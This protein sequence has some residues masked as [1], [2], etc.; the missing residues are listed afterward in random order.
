[1]FFR[2]SLINAFKENSPIF[3]IDKKGQAELMETLL[4]LLVIVLLIVSGIF[5]YYK[6]FLNSL[7]NLGTEKED[8]QNLILLYVFSSMPEVKCENDDCVDAV[9]LIAFKDLINENK[10]YYFSKFGYK[11]IIV[12]D[13]YPESKNSS[14][15]VECTIDKY[16]QSVFP[17]NCG[18]FVVYDNLNAKE[19]YGVSLPVSLYFANLNEYKIGRIIIKK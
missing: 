13:V 1:M 17:E 18:F 12:E 19:S 7:G 2:R 6:F 16:Q 15:T 8:T 14:K 10:A 9:K 4:I 5:V 11:K 3:L